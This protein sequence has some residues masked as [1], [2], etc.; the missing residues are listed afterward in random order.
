[1]SLSRRALDAAL[2]AR[3]GN[4]GC[5][6]RHG[7]GVEELSRK[8]DRWVARVS[9]GGM[10]CA[11]SVFLAT[12]K[13]DLR[14]WNRPASGHADLVG[15][16]MHWRLS[17]GQTE[18]LRRFMDL[19]LF[20][21]GYGGLS[22]VEED[23]ANLCLVVRRTRLRQMG[24]WQKFL[25]GLRQENSLLA[26][27]LTDGQ[28]AWDRPLAVASIPYGYLCEEERGGWLVGDQAAVIPS[29]T[30]DG[31]AI[32]LHSGALA[33]EMYL[34][35]NSAGEYQRALRDQLKANMRVAMM[36][37]RAMVS[38][39]GCRLAPH[40]IPLLAQPIGWIA[41]STRIPAKALQASSA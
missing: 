37:S 38:S 26:E 14:G 28:P 40:I 29:F 35:G 19:F 17:G 20:E 41:R 9:D 12:G 1:M 11:R 6:V 10:F 25:A 3:A 36:L 23:G 15:F 18:A 13:H 22:L 32:A 24:G 39:A 4:A 31:M 7:M 21:G 34:A 5:D 27:R 8:G 16:K 30:G 33:A 2:L